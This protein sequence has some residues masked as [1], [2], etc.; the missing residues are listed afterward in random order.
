MLKKEIAIKTIKLIAKPGTNAVVG[1]LGKKSNAERK[2]IRIEKKE[3]VEVAL[4]QKNPPRIAGKNTNNI[5][6][7]VVDKVK[8]SLT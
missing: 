2:P 6:K 5:N 8:I 4:F 1:I 3:A 7:A